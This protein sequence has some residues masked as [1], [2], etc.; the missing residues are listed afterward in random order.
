MKDYF[1]EMIDEFLEKNEIT[2]KTQQT[3]NFQNN[4]TLS[5]FQY[6]QS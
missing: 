6:S 4:Q 3:E 5:C 1:Q 2:D